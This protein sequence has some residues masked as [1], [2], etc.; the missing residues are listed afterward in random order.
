MRDYSA[1]E[2]ADFYLD[3]TKYRRRRLVESHLQALEAKEDNFSSVFVMYQQLH[4]LMLSAAP[5]L[6][7]SCQEAFDHMKVEMFPG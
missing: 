2:V 1:L 6:V 4:T 7:F 5:I 3:F